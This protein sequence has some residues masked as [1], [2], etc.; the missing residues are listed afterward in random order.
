M[1]AEQVHFSYRLLQTAIDNEIIDDE[2]MTLYSACLKKINEFG[3]VGGENCRK[4]E[5]LKT[6][7]VYN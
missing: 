7:M 1:A 6:T 5:I 2:M 4:T 3:G